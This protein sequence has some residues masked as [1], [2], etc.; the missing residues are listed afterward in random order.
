MGWTPSECLWTKIRPSQENQT[1]LICCQKLIPSSNDLWFNATGVMYNDTRT[2]K[3]ALWKYGQAWRSNMIQT[4]RRD[5]FRIKTNPNMLPGTSWRIKSG[6][7]TI[8][9][10]SAPHE[11][12]TRIKEK[13]IN[14]T[15][16]V[17][18]PHPI[19]YSSSVTLEQDNHPQWGLPPHCRL[20]LSS[21]SYKY[22]S[23]D[24]TDM[25]GQTGLHTT[26]DRYCYKKGGVWPTSECPRRCGHRNV[27]M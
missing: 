1:I 17:S 15:V 24:Q 23:Q 25:S 4:Q 16:R 6:G 26:A 5:G 27:D 13:Y 7:F 10:Q 20:E 9:S 3:L 8:T 12:I 11:N 22:C 2:T 18:R 14:K 19:L 21:T